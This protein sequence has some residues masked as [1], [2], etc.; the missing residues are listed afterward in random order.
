MKPLS[1]EGTKMVE[2]PTRNDFFVTKYG[3]TKKNKE[4]DE[5]NRRKESYF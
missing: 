3:R 5:R 2:H 1:I 4:Q